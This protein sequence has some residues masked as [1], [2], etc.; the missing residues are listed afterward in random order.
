MAARVLTPKPSVPMLA[1]R[2]LLQKFGIHPKDKQAVKLKMA[3]TR[4][5]CIAT[6][7]GV[8]DIGVATGVF[9]SELTVPYYCFL[10]AGMQVDVASPLGGIVPVDPLSMKE[11]I[12][13]PED[14]RLL[15]DQVFR[16]KLM[17]SLPIGDLDFTAYDIIYFAGGWGA[18]FDL[19]QSEELGRKVTAAYAAGRVL[20]GICHGPLGLL[21]GRTPDGELI[22][23]GRRLTSVTDKQVRELGI[24]ITPLHP[25]TALREAGALFESKTHKAR[26]FFAN[27]FVADGDLITGQNQNAGPMVARLMMQRVLAKRAS[28]RKDPHDAVR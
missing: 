14:D 25:E 26:D 5:L 1:S 10:D 28:K 13:T 15:S 7:Q 3:G 4:A 20:G 17:R 11:E 2:Q 23:K 18:A 6:N 8:L 27:H 12:R 19:G 22:V 16:Q 24:G 9:A 21:R